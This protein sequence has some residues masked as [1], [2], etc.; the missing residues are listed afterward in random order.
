MLL[1]PLRATR[2]GRRAGEFP[3]ATVQWTPQGV[4]L[5]CPDHQLAERLRQVF[6][7]PL[8]ARVAR[9]AAGEVQGHRWVELPPGT[10]E[11]FREALLRLHRLDLVARPG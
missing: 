4:V 9:V 3:L 8:K 6:F 10:E 1:Y 7:R 11:H 2:E 5:E